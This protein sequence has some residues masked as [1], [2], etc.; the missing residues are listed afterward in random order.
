MF[1]FSGILSFITMLGTLMYN[2]IDF[3]RRQEAIDE[4]KRM[5]ENEFAVEKEKID[6][7]QTEILIQD[8]TKEDV[9]KKMEDGT[10]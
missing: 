6:K 3:F 5:R 4:G 9:V 8:R 10:F 2:V 1:S 7:E